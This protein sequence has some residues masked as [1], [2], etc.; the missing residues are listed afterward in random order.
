MVKVGIQLKLLVE[1]G[2]AEVLGDSIE[3]QQV[4][5]NLI[6]NALEAMEQGGTLTVSAKNGVL[7]FDRKRRAVVLEVRDSGSGIPLEQQKS[8]F[9]PFFTTKHTG[10]GLGLAISHRIVTRHGGL[11]SFESE[12]E[13][14]TTFTVELPAAPER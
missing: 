10:T 13:V 1:D 12:P 3:I 9:N 7:S 6:Q 5:T 2:L 14:G 4:L 11:I 8:I